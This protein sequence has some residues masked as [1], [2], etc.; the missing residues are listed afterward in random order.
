MSPLLSPFRNSLAI[1]RFEDEYEQSVAPMMQEGYSPYFH[2]MHLSQ[3]DW[4]PGALTETN[5]THDFFG[6]AAAPY[7]AVSEV[8]RILLKDTSPALDGILFFK[9]T[10]WLRPLAF[11]SDTERMWL[12]DSPDSRC[13]SGISALG[14]M[15]EDDE[16]NVAPRLAVEAANVAHEM[17]SNYAINPNAWCSG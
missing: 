10:S 4:T 13:F 12:L 2:T 14:G 16:A 17:D 5:I 11:K 9:D 6:A 1:V 3:P 7:A 15:S 8:V